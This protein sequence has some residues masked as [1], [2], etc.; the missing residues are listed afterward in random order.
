[1]KEK[2]YDTHCH[3]NLLD[4]NKE[5]YKNI[6]NI[7]ENNLV[8]ICIGTDFKNSLTAIELANKY[9]NIIYSTIGIH[10][11]DVDLFLDEKEKIFHDFEK[12]LKGNKNIVGIGETGLDYYRN[13]SSKQ[14]QKIFF[15]QHI[16]LAKKFSLPL[17]VHVRDAYDDVYEIL[18][19]EKHKHV[20]IHCYSSNWNNAKRFLDIGCMI[21]FAGPI[22]FPKSIEL[23]EVVQ[24]I[25]IDK[26]VLETDAPWLA[27]VPFRGHRN[28]PINVIHIYKKV[29][30][31][32][33]IELDELIKQ[34]EINVKKFFKFI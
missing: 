9:E 12:L 2:Y 24:K 14:N 5:L 15:S 26:F 22:T 18:K 10:P 16:H 3:L 8:A 7:Q 13:F 28:E 11:N 4:D 27:P 25:P 33:K 31:I 21:S 17:I 32:K 1:M 19:K 6:K 23:Q 29:C 34:I 30:E 20:L